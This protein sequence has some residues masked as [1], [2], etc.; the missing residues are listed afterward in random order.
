MT[1]PTDPNADARVEVLAVDDM[2]GNLLAVET[3]LADLDINLVTARSGEEALRKVL[4]GDFA[5]IIMDVRMPG[6]GGYEAARLIRQREK[7][8]HTPIIFLTAYQADDTAILEAY[9]QGA[10]DHLTKPLIPDILRAKVLGFVQLYEYRQQVKRQAEQLRDL[11]RREFERKLIEEKQ[12]WEL[13]HLRDEARRK[14]EFLAVLS[15]ELRNPLAPVRNAVRVLQQVGSA[16]AA[17]VQAREV[18]DR[19]I[20]KMTRLVDDL[21]DVSR[22]TRGKV[23]LRK[24][25]VELNRAIHQAVETSRPHIEA[26]RHQLEVCTTPA[27]VWLDADPTRLEQVLSNLL[28]NAAKYT[29]PGGRIWLAAARQGEEAVV[30]VRDTG[31]GIRPEMLPHVFELFTQEGRAAEGAPPGLGIGL[32]LV[33]SLV[34]MHGGTVAARSDGPG[35]GSEFIVRLP[36]R[37]T[38]PEGEPGAAP[39]KRVRAPAR[40]ILIVDDNI[41]AA[42]SCA[43][44]LRLQ[45]HTTRVAH[46]GP[47]ALEMVCEYRPDVVLLDIGLPHGMSGHDVA[48]ELRR[49][50]AT[51]SAL[52][53][54]MTGYG[55]EDDYLQSREAGFD[56]HL[57]KPADPDLLQQLLGADRP[58]LVNP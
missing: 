18:I 57:T 46:D 48:R 36:V 23:E 34:E 58:A 33:R 6:I 38:A 20:H 22:I 56:H 32:T 45:G 44:L 30:S 31:I 14:D 1:T 51:R 52:L 28:D 19:Q 7:S 3:I 35:K 53:I 47:S 2:P 55:Q 8:R 4:Q 39:E 25:P 40:R 49:Q 15:H 16:D 5:V 24:Q 13:E 21:L 27:P 37:A 50:P 10:V 54:A 11:E 42:E 17:A 9:K 12:R 26:R 29:E 43:L 41:D